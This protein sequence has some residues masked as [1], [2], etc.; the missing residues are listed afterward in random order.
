MQYKGAR[1]PLPEIARELNVDAVVEGSVQRAGARVRIT[2][3]LIHAPTDK[4]LWAQSYERDLRDVLALQSEVASAIAAG[5]R[6]KVT[7]SEEARLARTGPV[8]PQAHELYLKGRYYWNRRTEEG[9]R[10]GLAYFQEAIEKDPSYALAYVGVADSYALLGSN[11][12][13]SAQP[14]REVRPLGKAAAL[15][16]LEIDP[17]LG[18]AH[19]SL[20]AA[21]HYYDWDW[22][23]AEREYRRAFELNPNYAQ[24]RVWYANYLMMF[25]RYAES[26]AEARRA[27][28]LDPLSLVTNTSVGWRFYFARRYDDALAE[29]RKALELDPSFPLARH[30]L[31]WAYEQKRMPEAAI[32]EFRQALALSPDNPITLASLGHAYALAGNELEARKVLVQLE[33]LSKRR[34]VPAYFVAVIYIGLGQKEQALQWLGRAYDE[35]SDELVYIKVEPRLDPLRDDPRF[36]ALVR[37]M[38][39]PD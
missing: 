13:S 14:P 8:N 30:C 36:Q 1:K 5:I 32:A 24:A 37:R 31:G 39:F 20:A 28:E 35:R 19:A 23:A 12:V 6:V 4:H 21:H 26:L 29:Y 15:K 10:K 11:L 34:Y 7:P 38:N 22:A 3:Q 16:A 2:A 17:N 9:L 18:E 33:Q 25:G 27:R